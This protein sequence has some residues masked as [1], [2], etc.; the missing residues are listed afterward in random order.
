MLR[1]TMDVRLELCEIEGE[2]RARNISVAQLC[3]LGGLNQ[4]TWVRWKNGQ[5][6][7]AQSWER[8]K[9]AYRRLTQAGEAAA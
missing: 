5:P 1:I 8:A 9:D 2:L 7:K 3:R 4:T 6:A